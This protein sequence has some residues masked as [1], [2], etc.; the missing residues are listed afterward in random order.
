MSIKFIIKDMN[1]PYGTC[2]LYTVIVHLT[3]LYEGHRAFKFLMKDLGF[4]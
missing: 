3:S 4:Y 1:K 2:R